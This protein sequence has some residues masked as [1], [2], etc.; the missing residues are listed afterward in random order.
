MSQTDEPIAEMSRSSAKA[1]SSAQIIADLFGA[2]KELIENSIDANATVIRVFLTDY[3][4]STIE[5]QDDGDGMAQQSASLFSELNVTSKL[6]RFDTISTLETFG[7]RGQALAALVALSQSVKISSKQRE[8]KGWSCIFSNGHLVE[9][10]TTTDQQSAGTKILITDLFDTL[11]VRRQHF[12]AQ[13]KKTFNKA[14]LRL[15]QYC[16]VPCLLEEATLKINNTV[17]SPTLT[18]VQIYHNDKLLAS[19]PNKKSILNCMVRLLGDRS[20]AGVHLVNWDLPIEDKDGNNHDELNDARSQ[21][22]VRGVL[23]TSPNAASAIHFAYINGRPVDFPRLHKVLSQSMFNIYVPSAGSKSSHTLSY[24]LHLQL[25]KRISLDFNLTPDKRKVLVE[26]EDAICVAIGGMA[27]DFFMQLYAKS[28]RQ[29]VAQE[30]LCNRKRPITQLKE[31]PDACSN[32]S[33]KDA[34]ELCANHTQVKL[35][36]ENIDSDA[37]LSMLTDHGTLHVRKDSIGE[38]HEPPA[39]DNSELTSEQSKDVRLKIPESIVSQDKKHPHETSWASSPQVNRP[40]EKSIL[41]S[42]LPA[43]AA[44]TTATREEEIPLLCIGDF[45]KMQ[46]IGQFNNGFIITKLGGDLYIIDQHASDEKFRY[47][48][49]VEHAKSNICTQRLLKPYELYG[50]LL[51]RAD[52]L[53]AMQQRLID[54]GITITEGTNEREKGPSSYQLFVSHVP[55]TNGRVCTQDDVEDMLHRLLS[56]APNETVLPRGTEDKFASKACRSAV[57][58]GDALDKRQMKS[59]VHAMAGL[60]HPWNCPHGRPT[61]RKLFQFGGS[62]LW[63][64]PDTH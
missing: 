58:I 49:L 41:A 17:K 37:A 38:K 50:T 35:E 23:G 25:P 4:T 63:S 11:P 31:D 7:F 9:E 34:I 14:I 27:K 40:Y 10:P 30:S 43:T 53:L 45:S 8:G 16:F 39:Y 62:V 55:V 22:Q 6:R 61:V 24:V 2:V 32:E 51:N 20:I 57:M 52:E 42:M 19:T 21:L 26:E 28:A 29:A 64:K 12:L 59:I 44:Q 47:E 60:M 3:G 36:P 15:F 5:V 54:H 13:N 56:S 1:I 18:D 46:I 33:R 48:A